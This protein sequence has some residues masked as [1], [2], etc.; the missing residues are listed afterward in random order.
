[1]WPGS[2]STSIRR[3]RWIA[4]IILTSFC[5]LPRIEFV[6]TVG[7]DEENAAASLLIKRRLRNE[8]S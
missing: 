1:M 6:Q 3:K 5:K 7:G 8:N 2:V 4:S